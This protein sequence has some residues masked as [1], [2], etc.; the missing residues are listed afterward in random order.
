VLVVFAHINWLYWSTCP[1]LGFYLAL[2]HQHAS[3]EETVGRTTVGSKNINIAFAQMQTADDGLSQTTALNTQL[4][5]G[6][7]KEVDMV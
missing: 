7:C 2:D 3:G 6:G 4:S 5:C 1:C